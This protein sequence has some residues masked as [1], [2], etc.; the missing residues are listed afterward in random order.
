MY[1]N[2]CVTL[3]RTKHAAAPH[4]APPTHQTRLR[5]AARLPRVHILSMSK[6]IS[7]CFYYNMNTVLCLAHMFLAHGGFFSYSEGFY[8]SFLTLM[9][10]F[11]FV[12]FSV[13]AFME[14]CLR[15]VNIFNTHRYSS[16]ILVA[17]RVPTVRKSPLDRRG[18]LACSSIAKQPNVLHNAQYMCCRHTSPP[19][20][21]F[22]F[23]LCR[24][25][26]LAQTLFH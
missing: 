3:A 12:L 14:P 4:L 17:W 8:Y 19:L 9:F 21:S 23:S 11:V 13:F 18:Y 26:A 22:E 1:A 25:R 7:F 5:R 10:C 2:T 6:A 15:T 16:L 24:V 20:F